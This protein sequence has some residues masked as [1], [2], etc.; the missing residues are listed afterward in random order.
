MVT[1][2]KKNQGSQDLK[3]NVTT[4][5]LDGV[6]SKTQTVFTGLQ[7]FMN[8]ALD[9]AILSGMK[10][11]T[12]VSS[13]VQSNL[14]KAIAIQKSAN[15]PGSWFGP[16][17]DG[18]YTETYQSSGFTYTNKVKCKDSTMTSIFS[19]EYNGADGRFSYVY[20]TQLTEY[21]KNKVALW[22]GYS[23]WKISNYGD[24]EISDARWT[25]NFSDW[26]SKTG[27]GYYDWWCGSHSL[28]G[29]SQAYKRFMSVMA[30][31]KGYLNS[32]PL[33][34]IKLTWYDGAYEY[35][36]EYDSTWTPVDMPDMICV[37]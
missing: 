1:S 22:K 12:P 5:Q 30:F 14:S 34:H 10:I 3:G 33:L 17:A 29:D 4:A 24:N 15:G 9:S 6:S 2:C 37:H 20:E 35:S 16:D 31:E 11:T 18:W 25:F 7:T 27:A 21:T 23:D 28:G 32:L 13:S 19:M 8:N 36:Y 26:N